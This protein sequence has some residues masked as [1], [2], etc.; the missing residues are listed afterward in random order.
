MDLDQC[1]VSTLS[2]HPLNYS[3]KW[4]LDWVCL[5]WETCSTI[6]SAG[7]STTTLGTWLALLH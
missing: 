2:P 3:Q 4:T 5:S 1:E 6:M 7:G